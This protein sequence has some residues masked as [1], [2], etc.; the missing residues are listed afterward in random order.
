MRVSVKNNRHA[1]QSIAAVW[2]FAVVFSKEEEVIG[3]KMGIS[4]KVLA[5]ARQKPNDDTYS[6]SP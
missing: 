4:Y 1:I 5:F 3:G 2:I 6:P